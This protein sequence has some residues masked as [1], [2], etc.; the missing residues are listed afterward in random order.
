MRVLLVTPGDGSPTCMPFAQ[1][2]EASVLK[3]GIDVRNFWLLS[4]TSP[5]VIFNERLRFRKEIRRFKP[6]IVHAYYG[7]VTSFFCLMNS[8]KPLIITF[9]GSDLNPVPSDNFFRYVFS[10]LLSQLSA[11][12]AKRIVCV[13]K[14]LKR[15][16][17]WK[18]DR[19]SVIPCGIN[20]NI[21]KPMEREKARN[22]LGW[23]EVD[24]IILFNARTDP[25]GK[26]LD[27]A[28]SAIKLVKESLPDTKLFVFQGKTPPSE[29]PLYYSAADAFLMTSDFEGSPMVIKEALACNLPVVSVDV[30]DVSK[31]IENVHPSYIVKRD[32]RA[33]ADALVQILTSLARSNGREIVKEI[34]EDRVAEQV[35]ELYREIL[36]KR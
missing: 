14:G 12:F 18:K 24:K 3:A 19:S 30:G 25:I 10:Y 5:K 36:S 11:L 8:R 29:M 33:L 34:S 31:R 22:R 16:L 7:T 27:L 20:M 26:R 17:W 6:D 35:I 13:S 28:E 21:F 23:D 4:R 9:H 32:P 1:R 15:R 2:F